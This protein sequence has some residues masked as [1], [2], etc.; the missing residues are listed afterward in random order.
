MK[1]IHPLVLAF[2]VVGLLAAVMALRDR[3]QVE[4]RNRAVQLVLDYDEVR[5]LAAATGRT[6]EQALAA[7]KSAGIRGIA[8]TEETLGNLRDGGSLQIVAVPTPSGV[9]QEVRISNAATFARVQEYL[10]HKMPP[11]SDPSGAVFVGPN[12]E[13]FNGGSRWKDVAGTP[14][15]P[16]PDTVAEVRAAGLQVVARVGNFTSATPESIA[17]TFRKVKETG[18][19]TVIFNGDSVIGFKDLL[20]AT[21][22]SLRA[23][24]LQYG[25]IE[26]GKQRGDEAL[27]SLLKA[28]FVRVHSI[29]GAELPRL[30]PEDAVERYVRGIEE[31]NIR[32]GY[33]RLMDNVGKSVD[34]QQQTFAQNVAYVEKIGKELERSGYTLGEAHPFEPVHAGGMAGMLISALIAFGIGAG[35]A[36]LLATVLPLG[37]PQQVLL[38]AAFGCAAVGLVLSGVSIARQGV[39]FGAALVFP[40]LAFTLF[41]QPVGAFENHRYAPASDRRPGIGGTVLTFIAMSLVSLCG[42]LMVAGLL[43]ELPYMMKVEEFKGIKLAH[44]LPLA[45]VGIVY[46]AGLTGAYPNWGQEKRETGD[47]VRGLFAEPLRVWHA[48]AVMV[49]VVA[50]AML[51]LR[52]GND[53]GVGVSPI[54]M[55]FRSLLDR[56]LVRP[57]TKEFMIGHPALI[58]ALAMATWPRWRRYALPLLLV[59][60]IGQVSLLNSFCHIHTPIPMT[61]YRTFNGLWIGVVLGVALV[62]VANRFLFREKAG[63]PK[64]KPTRR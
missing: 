8:V 41:A 48:I 1:R 31:R 44:A 9:R 14:I 45:I 10:T 38:A 53:P 33:V 61:L 63:K 21:G 18:A 62:M 24:G 30:S 64:V 50:L 29:P 34:G 27:S 15:G 16:D 55:K 12:G 19:T 6:P 54:E 42:G 39:A 40:T 7:M 2:V 17:W 20:K 49:G 57:R 58:L 22:E 52:T 5:S 28:Q 51:L 11:V 36:M 43:S 32:L 13:R 37:R 26:F 3:W 35:A 4:Q 25:S 59:G 60:A 46:T 23:N 56:F 47:R